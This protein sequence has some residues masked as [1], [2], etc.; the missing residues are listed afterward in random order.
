MSDAESR[1]D[2]LEAKVRTLEK[3]NRVLVAQKA[4][5]EESSRENSQDLSDLLKTVEKLKAQLASAGIKQRE[6]AKALQF[7]TEQLEARE[8]ETAELRISSQ[9]LGED[10]DQL[11]QEV[12]FGG[13]A[14][15]VVEREIS[16]SE[17]A[18]I[19]EL[20]AENRNLLAQLLEARRRMK[21][22]L[23]LLDELKSDPNLA[24]FHG[25]S[26]K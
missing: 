22:Q 13:G 12:A 26:A 2:K 11:R 5:L 7:T 6:T 19:D 14:T 20:E 23:E 24:G 18:Y 25:R 17:M 15:R 16:R 1:A 8:T 9:M 10:L 3:R 21:E 4:K